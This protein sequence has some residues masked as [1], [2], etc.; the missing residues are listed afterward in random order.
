VLQFTASE[1]CW[2]GDAKLVRLLTDWAA[3]CAAVE[4]PLLADN[5]GAAA[6][7]ME[8]LH[9]AGSASAAGGVGEVPAIIS[10]LVAV[11]VMVMVA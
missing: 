11:V 10:V 2:S 9:G 7:A 3:K 8:H 4:K 5:P 1:R 6:Y